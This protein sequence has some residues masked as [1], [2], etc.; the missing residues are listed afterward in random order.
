MF[1]VNKQMEFSDFLS[2]PAE[3]LKVKLE[4]AF[5]RTK[6]KV[7]ELITALQARGDKEIL[8]DF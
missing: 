1:L 4:E 8:M 5:N 2:T 6:S 3:S 7:K